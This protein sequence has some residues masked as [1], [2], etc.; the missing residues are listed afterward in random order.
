M[1]AVRNFFIRLSHP[2]FC[3]SWCQPQLCI[4][5]CSRD[6]IHGHSIALL[7]TG[8]L[9]YTNHLC[10]QLGF[11]LSYTGMVHTYLHALKLDIISILIA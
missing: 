11:K 3:K 2:A 6:I 8:S 9:F 7:P 5:L 1:K 10:R 4:Q